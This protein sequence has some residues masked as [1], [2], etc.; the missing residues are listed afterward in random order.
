MDLRDNLVLI[1]CKFKVMLN[2]IVTTVKDSKVTSL[3]RKKN[4]KCGKR[5]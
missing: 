3:E 2:Y 4:I 5:K 1:P